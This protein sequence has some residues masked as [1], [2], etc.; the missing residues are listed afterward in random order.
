[1]NLIYDI[2][3]QYKTSDNDAVMFDIDDTLIRSAD[4]VVIFGSLN[5]LKRARK[6]GY[7]IVIITAR[8]PNGAEYTSTQLDMAG[9]P[10]DILI[11]SPAHMKGQV[12]RN[13][14]HRYVLSVGD[15]LTD[16]TDSMFSLKLPGPTDS[17]MGFNPQP[18]GHFY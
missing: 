3:S 9:I 2:L 11:F 5:I 10:Y 17:T 12:K 16:C 15:L 14:G 4:G 8:S 18:G 13:T 1:M 7:K 6:L